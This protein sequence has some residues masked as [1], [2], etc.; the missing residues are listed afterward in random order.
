MRVILQEKSNLG[1]VG[2]QVMVRPG[3]A[4]NFLLPTQKR[5]WRHLKI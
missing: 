2:D 5:F 4:R 1:K 3:F